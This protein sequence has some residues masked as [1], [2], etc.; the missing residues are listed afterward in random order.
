[1]CTCNAMYNLEDPGFAEERLSVCLS[2]WLLG[3]VGMMPA[4]RHL[5]G[6]MRP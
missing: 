2:G 4:P 6:A 3:P 1:M 5:R